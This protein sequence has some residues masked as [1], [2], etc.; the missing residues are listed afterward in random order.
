M[1]LQLV[2][3]IALILLVVL[4]APWLVMMIV[5]G[6]SDLTLVGVSAGSFLMLCLLVLGIRWVR[7]RR[8]GGVESLERRARRLAEES[9]Q[10]YRAARRQEG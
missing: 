9:N 8:K 10:R 2:I 5:P 4:G 3:L 1:I 6:V 7:G